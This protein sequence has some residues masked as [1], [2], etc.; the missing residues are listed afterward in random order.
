VGGASRPPTR[1]RHDSVV[2]GCCRVVPCGPERAEEVHRL[3]QAAFEP[4]RHLDP[5]SGAVRETVEVVRGDLARGGGA[6]AALYGDAVGCLRWFVDAGDLH[7]RRLAVEPSLQGRG[8]GR[9]LMA[10]AE[11]EAARRGCEGVAV[12]VRC[13]LMGNLAFYGRLGY[14]VVGDGRHEGYDVPTWLRLRKQLAGAR[15]SGP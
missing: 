6:I 13:A 8:I 1:R 2:D 7:V 10:W 5:P 15:A 14:S 9:L 4:H 12:G 11:D 3:T